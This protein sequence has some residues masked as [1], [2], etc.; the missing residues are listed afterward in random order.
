MSY[1]P[2]EPRNKK[3]EWV[4][5]G[6]EYSAYVEKKTEQAKSKLKRDLEIVKNITYDSPRDKKNAVTT[7]KMDFNSR[8]NDAH[9]NAKNSEVRRIRE[10]TVDIKKAAKRHAQV[11]EKSHYPKQLNYKHDVQP[12]FKKYGL[13]RLLPSEKRILD[14][15]TK[16]LLSEDKAKGRSTTSLASD[17]K[18]SNA[19]DILRYG[20][21]YGKVAVS[22]NNKFF[23][24]VVD[25]LN[26]SEPIIK[27]AIKNKKPFNFK[28]RTGK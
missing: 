5:G 2:K 26:I 3:G 19:M 21:T 10:S 15:M 27:S 4:V 22:E 18:V 24:H 6:P 9:L 14:D 25:S 8:I 12:L 11:I 28:I 20:S 23:K 16:R 13:R 17:N 7:A 1:N